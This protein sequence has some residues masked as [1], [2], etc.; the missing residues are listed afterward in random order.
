MERLSC[1]I[2]E[3]RAHSEGRWMVEKLKDVIPRHMFKVSIQAVL[4]GKVIA[5]EHISPYRKGKRPLYAIFLS[6]FQTLFLSGT[7][8]DAFQSKFTE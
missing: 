3:E 8:D 7:G 4:G 2:H 1:V 5:S 6:M